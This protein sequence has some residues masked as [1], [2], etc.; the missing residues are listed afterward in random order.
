M[1]DARASREV[2]RRGRAAWFVA[3]DAVEVVVAVAVVEEDIR[4]LEASMGMAEFMRAASWS[5]EGILADEAG[6]VAVA[7]AVGAREDSSTGG[8]RLSDMILSRPPAICL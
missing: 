5:K 6:R 7:V 3:G 8:V 2:G 1:E 4:E